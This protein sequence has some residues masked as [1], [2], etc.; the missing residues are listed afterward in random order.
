MPILGYRIGNFA[1]LTDVKY[2]PEEEILKL[3]GV[4]TLVLSALRKKEHLS[5]ENWM[6]P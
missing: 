5:H 6:K 2:V 1:Y 4:D 3:K